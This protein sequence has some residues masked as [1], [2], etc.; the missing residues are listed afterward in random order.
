MEDS[1]SG[2]LPSEAPGGQSGANRF[3]IIADPRFADRLSLHR[4]FWPKLPPSPGDNLTR[5]F[6]PVKKKILFSFIFHLFTTQ[7]HPKSHSHLTMAEVQDAPQVSYEELAGIED[8]FEQIDTE[9]S[10]FSPLSTSID[11]LQS[12]HTNRDFN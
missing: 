5:T 10:E 3:F 11:T 6:F 2:T 8:Q 4:H 1:T 7:K 12:A 9:I